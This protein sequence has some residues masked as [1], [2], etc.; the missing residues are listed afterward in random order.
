MGISYAKESLDYMKEELLRAWQ[1]GKDEVIFKV[2]DIRSIKG[3]DDGQSSIS[4]SILELCGKFKEAGAGYSYYPVK[5]P[6]LETNIANLHGLTLTVR[7]RFPLDRDLKKVLECNKRG[8]RKS[9]EKEF[10]AERI[11]R[12]GKNSESLI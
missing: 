6:E 9:I 4:G 5:F 8:I 2:K 3:W 10:V 11:R 1:A 7:F 12:E